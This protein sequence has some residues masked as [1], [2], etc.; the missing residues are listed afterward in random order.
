METGSG[1]DPVGVLTPTFS[2]IG[3]PNVHGPSLFTAVLL[4][5]VCNPSVLPTVAEL[6]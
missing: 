2:V 6:R 1:G 5:M 4:Y 3:G